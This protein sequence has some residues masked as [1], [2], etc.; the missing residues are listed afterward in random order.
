[1]GKVLIQIFLPRADNKGQPFPGDFFKRISL[2]LNECFGGVTIYQQTP[3]TG[4]WKDDE[5][6]TVKDELI[7]YEVMAEKMDPD[8]W[9]PFR[10]KLEHQLRQESILIRSYQIQVL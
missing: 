3:V 1:M 7:I 9:E 5:Q 8:F 2:E 4:L 10:K 6:D